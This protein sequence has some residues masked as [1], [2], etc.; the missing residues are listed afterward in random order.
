[1]SRG[2]YR[3]PIG[4]RINRDELLRFEFEGRGLDGFRGDTLASALLATGVTLAGR[5]FKYHRPRGF[6]SAGVEE[7]NG[8]MTLGH[9]ARTTPN[10]PATVTELCEGLIA[11]R[12]NGWPS[13]E[14]D[15]KAAL[16]WF[17]PLLGAGFYY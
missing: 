5:S 7:P 12:Q 4:G 3:L 16:G 14:F 11:R 1:M 8:L 17:A 6:L 9:G 10:V 2:P 13:I 15:V